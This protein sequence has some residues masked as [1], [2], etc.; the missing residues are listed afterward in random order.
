MDWTTRIRTELARHQT[1]PDDDIVLE[2]AQHADAAFEA[3]RA[4]GLSASEASVRV[5]DLIAAWSRDPALARRR[6]RRSAL[7]VPPPPASS[8]GAV[9]VWAD[10]VYGFRLVRRQ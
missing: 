4:E 5:N 3:A 7:A 9:G 6:P 1:T 10:I 2:L 8:R